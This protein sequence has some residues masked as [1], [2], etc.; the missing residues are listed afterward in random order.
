MGVDPSLTDFN[1]TGKDEYIEDVAA[2]DAW[3]CLIF[4][5]TNGHGWDHA[6][7]D[8]RNGS[9]LRRPAERIRRVDLGAGDGRRQQR[10]PACPHRPHGLRFDSTG[11]QL[12][13]FNLF[14]ARGQET[15]ALWRLMYP[16]S[17]TFEHDSHR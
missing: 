14:G 4:I 7:V 13:R 5:G 1:V 10:H 16:A 2:V 12:G 15:A 9:I 3:H 6:F 11:R 17:T 8:L